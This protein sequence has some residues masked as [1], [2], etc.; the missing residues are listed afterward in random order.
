MSIAAD[1]D[2]TLRPASAS[3]QLE[4]ESVMSPEASPWRTQK[5]NRR[6]LLA[7]GALG[8]AVCG[9]MGYAALERYAESSADHSL[10]R[11][12]GEDPPLPRGTD[13]RRMAEDIIGEPRRGLIPDALEPPAQPAPAVSSPE[14]NDPLVSVVDVD[15]LRPPRGAPLDSAIAGPEDEWH[16]ARLSALREA[17]TAQ[18]TIRFDRRSAGPQQQGDFVQREL[19]RVAAQRAALEGPSSP[20]VAYQQAASQASQILGAQAS[21]QASPVGPGGM[22]LAAS[23]PTAG[24][25]TSPAPRNDLRA[26]GKTSN[27]DRWQL[28]SQVEDPLSPYM[29]QVG[30]VIGAVLDSAVNSELPGPLIAHVS[31][32][33]YSST[34]SHELLIPQGST[35]FGEYSSDVVFGQDRLLVAWQRLRFPNG[36]T[37][38]IGAMPGTDGVGRAGFE[39]QVDHHYFRLFAS[40]LLLSLVTTGV[41]MT[42]TPSGSGE[43]MSA[44]SAMSQALGLQFGQVT[45]QL[46]QKNLNIAP[47][48]EI[49]NGFRFNI[50]VTKDLVFTG[51]YP[52]R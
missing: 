12:T 10:R 17:L 29:V 45:S 48:I 37:L 50:V 47:T 40:A 19:A 20:A 34:G 30:S 41:T 42:Q 44:G 21:A 11:S 32:P 22:P 43:T 5:L 23:A 39:D 52:S 25:S 2:D 38:D 7:L 1:S 46:L 13:S 33:V 3:Q 4:D 16:K 49:R 8:A 26:F 28:P 6:P 18:R 36:Q 15:P 9:L 24:A 27:N 31:Q 35:L 14:Q 51:P